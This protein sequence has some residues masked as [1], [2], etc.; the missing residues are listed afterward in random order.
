VS[1]DNGR[2]MERFRCAAVPNPGVGDGSTASRTRL[3]LDLFSTSGAASN[4]RR[5]A[6][7]SGWNCKAA[8]VFSSR[9]RS[10]SWKAPWQPR[11]GPLLTSANGV[12]TIGAERKQAPAEADTAPR[13][14]GTN[15]SSGTFFRLIEK[16][17]LGSGRMVR[18]VLIT[19]GAGFIGSHVTD[20]LLAAGYARQLLSFQPRTSFEQG[21]EELAGWLGEASAVDRVDEA[22]EELVRRGLVA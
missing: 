21:L 7:Q 1:G 19:G 13:L 11:P 14:T 9:A 22:T 3:V 15:D 5:F 17:Q 12:P 2:R 8:A 4:G 10:K 6:W 16:R 18:R 20:E